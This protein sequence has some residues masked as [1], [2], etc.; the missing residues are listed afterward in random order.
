MVEEIINVS[1]PLERH[2]TTRFVN[3]QGQD[4]HE[5]LYLDDI[6]PYSIEWVAAPDDVD[7]DLDP[8]L[9]DEQLSELERAGEEWD[10]E[11]AACEEE[12][13]QVDHAAE[14]PIT[15]V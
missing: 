7:Y 13:H 14:A 11:V 10:A 5:A 6:N 4:S 2:P 12:E 3:V 15:M 8:F 9:I 1:E